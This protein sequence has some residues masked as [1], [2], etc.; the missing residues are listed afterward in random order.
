MII[1]EKIIKDIFSLKIKMSGKDKIV[2]SKYQKYIPM[3]DIYSQQIYPIFQTNLYYRLIES[4]YRFINYEIKLWIENK[5]KKYKN[6]KN[7]GKIFKKNLEIINNYDIDILIDTSYKTLYEYSINLGLQISICKRNSFHPYIRHLKPYYSKNELIKLGENMHLIE[8]KNI[9]LDLLNEQKTHFELCKQISSNDIS[10]EIIKNNTEHIMNYNIIQWVTYYSFTG[11]FIFNKILRNKKNFN[12]FLY[13]GLGKLIDCIKNTI[14]LEKKFF[15]YR[16]IWNDEY[17]KALNINDTFIDHGFVSTTRDP[18]YSP[19][20]NGDFGLILIKIHLPKDKKGVGLFIEN[21]SLFPNEQ[22]FLIP[23]YSKFKLLSKDENF[24]YYH[25]NEEFEKLINTKY[26][27]EYI[28]TNYDI[29]PLYK[30]KNTN[31]Q[32]DLKN[33]IP[34]G[35][36]RIDIIKNFLED[37]NQIDIK[38]NNNIYESYFLWFDSTYLS[39]YAKLYASNIKDGITFSIYNNNYPY[40]NIEISDELNVNFINTLYFYEDTK[41]ELDNELLELIFHFGRI[42]QFKKAKIFHNY[43]NFSEFKNNY[44]LESKFF[45]YNNFY[46][47]TIYDYA[48]NNN[49]Q[50]N[51]DYIKYEIGWY[52]LNNFLN[53][54]LPDNLIDTYKL[55]YKNIKDNLIDIIE[56]NFSIYNIFIH[57]IN[58]NK[59]LVN[60]LDKKINLLKENYFIFNIYNKLIYEYEDKNIIFNPDMK[61]VNELDKGGNYKL[62]FKHPLRRY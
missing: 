51:N 19:G 41:K 60:L 38:F 2:L 28:D 11:S 7:L 8:N 50:L 3:Y 52:N 43:R 31:K 25:T 15:V 47:H 18:F 9:Q 46:N 13:I 58:N 39:P 14:E 17:I 27:F 48:K 10:F 35:D 56:N 6:D 5:Y 59:E 16:F 30:V 33:Y 55:K 54:I 49:K 12:S 32:I 36:V 20:L 42:F 29:L 24:K 37:Y 34:H 62:I 53:K 1:D 40:L 61:Y 45:L 26:E 23:P 22:E 21:F 44:N 4:H 57:E